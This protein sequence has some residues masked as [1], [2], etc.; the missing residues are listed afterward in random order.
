M[1]AAKSERGRAWA[2]L[3]PDVRQGVEQRDALDIHALQ[4]GQI[5]GQRDKSTSTAIAVHYLL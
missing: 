4:V 3:C 2:P 1:T 5:R